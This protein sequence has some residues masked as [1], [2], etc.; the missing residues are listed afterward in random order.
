MELIPFVDIHA[1]LDVLFFLDAGFGIGLRF[2]V[3]AS[4][5]NLG[6]PCFS[7]LLLDGAI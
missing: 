5:Q 1:E 6:I 2:G 7:D 4:P 3:R